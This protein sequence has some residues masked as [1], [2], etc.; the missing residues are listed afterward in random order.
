MQD[1]LSDQASL[2]LALNSLLVAIIAYFLRLG[3]S[4]MRRALSTITDL[5]QRFTAT[6]EV[7][8]SHAEKLD[9]HDRL[10][11]KFLMN[12]PRTGDKAH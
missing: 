11:E 10:I 2:M 8:K 7:L 4:I 9:R 3:V 6:V 12:D 5:Q 1:V